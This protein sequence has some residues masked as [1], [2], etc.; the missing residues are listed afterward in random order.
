M[1]AVRSTAG[2]C[3]GLLRLAA[4]SASSSLLLECC[5]VLKRGSDLWFAFYVL[6]PVVAPDCC[7]QL[8]ISCSVLVTH[9]R[10]LLRLAAGGC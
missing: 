1:L 8:L 3:I 9:N 6:F 7:W 2:C 5:Y 10:L 4:S